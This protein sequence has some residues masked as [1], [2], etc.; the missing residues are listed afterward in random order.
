MNPFKK[1][2]VGS[3]LVLTSILMYYNHYLS[4]GVFEIFSEASVFLVLGA[5]GIYFEYGKINS[6]NKNEIDEEE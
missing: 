2:V 5:L 3:V 6:Y 1:S 4:N